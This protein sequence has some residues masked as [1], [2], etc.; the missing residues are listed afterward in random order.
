MPDDDSDFDDSFLEALEKAFTPQMEVFGARFPEL[1]TEETRAIIITE[2]SGPIP[3]G[4]YGFVEFYCN[5][6]KCDCRRVQIRV[7]S[8]DRPPDNSWAGINFGWERVGFYRKWLKASKEDASEITGASL[9]PFAVNS[10]C[11][12][13]F[14][15]LFRTHL[16]TDQE[17][18]DRLARHYRLFKQ[19]LKK[20]SGIRKLGRTG[21]GRKKKRLR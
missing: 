1:A 21:G 11:A 8:E 13:C 17:Y 20:T 7:C 2:E 18:V 9:E 4:E 19:S 16:I 6:I 12:D 5:D 15:Q 14:L 10:E 3:P